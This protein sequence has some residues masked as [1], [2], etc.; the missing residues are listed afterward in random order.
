MYTHP[1]NTSSTSSATSSNRSGTTTKKLTPREFLQRHGTPVQ[2]STALSKQGHTQQSSNFFT[3]NGI[4]LPLPSSKVSRE[5]AEAAANLLLHVAR[6]GTGEGTVSTGMLIIIGSIDNYNDTS[7]G[8]SNTNTNHFEG[9]KFYVQQWSKNH[10]FIFPSFIQDGAMFIDGK[11]GLI[12]ADSFVLQL[13]TMYADQN[14]GTG[15]MQASAAGMQGCLAFKCSTDSC[16]NDGYGRGNVKVF[17][18]TKSPRYV[19]IQVS[20]R[21]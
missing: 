5:V 14:G 17:A 21:F 1:K 4:S 13:R 20:R 18:G 15:H 12:L 9:R 6:N 7:F 11:T 8:Y 3:M 16:T 2:K 10:R 19:P